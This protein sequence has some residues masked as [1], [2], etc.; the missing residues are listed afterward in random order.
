MLKPKPFEMTNPDV[1]ANGAACIVQVQIDPIY[2][3]FIER[4]PYVEH[5]TRFMVYSN[6]IHVWIDTRYNIEDAWLDLYE[7]LT[8]ETNP[9][10]LSS[11]WDIADDEGQ[12]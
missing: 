7:Q 10:E 1:S 2:H 12:G 5:I 9:I 4:L 8:V 3:E 6:H 11:V